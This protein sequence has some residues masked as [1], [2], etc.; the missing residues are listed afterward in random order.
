[1]TD[2]GAAG[3]LSMPDADPPATSSPAD[4]LRASGV[5]RGRSLAPPLAPPT[6]SGMVA[7]ADYR[8]RHLTRCW[9]LSV[10]EHILHRLQPTLAIRVAFF[11]GD[12]EQPFLAS[13]VW[14]GAPYVT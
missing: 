10:G 5:S 2:A 7:I 13:S 6:L 1:M 11:H 3:A 14:C 8:Q 12:F 9:A 4:H